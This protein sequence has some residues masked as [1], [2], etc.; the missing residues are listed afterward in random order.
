MSSPVVVVRN[1]LSDASTAVNS[2]PVRVAGQPFSVQSVAP[3][4]FVAIEGSND[5]E[6]WTVLTDIENNA[7]GSTSQSFQEEV[8]EQ[9]QWA[10]LVIATDAS[11]PRLYRCIFHIRKDNT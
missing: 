9:P 1:V 3:G 11:A 4:A 10:R 5:G 2:E 7:L 8:K 6:T